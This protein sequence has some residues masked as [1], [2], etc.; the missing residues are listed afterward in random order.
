MK[1][2]LLFAILPTLMSCGSS[3]NYEAPKSHDIEFVSTN[4]IKQGQ[5]YVRSAV[6][7]INK[8]EAVK[9]A[10]VVLDIYDEQGKLIGTGFKYV[11]DLKRG[12]KATLELSSEYNG[13]PYSTRPR[14]G[15]V[16]WYE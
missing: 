15:D 4:F 10:Q 6:E 1:K 7:L 16:F 12:E 5:R 8:G 9:A 11:K 2:L 3:T 13:E 14:I